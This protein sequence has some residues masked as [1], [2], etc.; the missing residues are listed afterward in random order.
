MFKKTALLQDS[1]GNC[2]P[3]VFGNIKKNQVVGHEQCNEQCNE[4]CKLPALNDTTILAIKHKQCD[5]NCKLIALNY[6]NILATLLDDNIVKVYDFNHTLF[7]NIELLPVINVGDINVIKMHI[8]HD[9]DDKMCIIILIIDI[10]N[11][12]HQWRYKK[13]WG[14]WKY[15]KIDI[16]IIANNIDFININSV[17]IDGSVYFNIIY[18]EISK[19]ELLPF[20]NIYQIMRGYDTVIINNNNHI[21][22]TMCDYILLNDGKLFKFNIKE[23]ILTNINDKKY[24]IN[25]LSGFEHYD[26]YGITD[27][28]QVINLRKMEVISDLPKGKINNICSNENNLYVQIDNDLYHKKLENDEIFRQVMYYDINLNEY[29]PAQFKPEKKLIKSAQNY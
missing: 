15:C 29:L 19:Y 1:E 8:D 5:E 3:Y 7:D 4:N 25:K 14:D 28:N 17:I 13:F 2:H 26:I 9:F 23:K 10:D 16:P 18:N 20:D 22:Y 12:I 21:K 6:T 24:K 27:D 11:N